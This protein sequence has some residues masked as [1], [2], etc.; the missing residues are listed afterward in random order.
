[1]EQDLIVSRALIELFG[2]PMLAQELRF[3][4]GTALH[5]LHN[6][7]REGTVCFS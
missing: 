7:R 6:L 2:D 4:G 3:R 5:K 1:V